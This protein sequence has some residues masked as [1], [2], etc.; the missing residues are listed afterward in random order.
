M[1]AAIDFFTTNDWFLALLDA[2]FGPLA[3]VFALWITTFGLRI[4]LFKPTDLPIIFDRRHGK[5]YRI[6]RE[7]QPGWRGLFKP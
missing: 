6:L 4:D 3:L 1:I 7:E 2:V 5:I